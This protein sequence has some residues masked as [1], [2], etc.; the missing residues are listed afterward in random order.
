MNSNCVT[1]HVP[2]SSDNAS[3]EVGDAITTT[4]QLGEKGA[5]ETDDSTGQTQ[6]IL[7]TG[8]GKQSRK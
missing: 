1:H 4:L 3:A 5:A 2:G 7:M 8:Q 6:Q